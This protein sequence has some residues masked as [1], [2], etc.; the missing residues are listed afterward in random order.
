M[1]IQNSLESVDSSLL[2]E[3]IFLYLEKNKPREGMVN[4]NTKM[5]IITFIAFPASVNECT[6]VSPKIPVRVRNV[7]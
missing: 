7:E 2:M 1:N 4:D 5:P 3:G 6:E